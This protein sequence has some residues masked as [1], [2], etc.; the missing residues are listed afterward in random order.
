MVV[1]VPTVLGAGVGTAATRAIGDDE[2]LA[3]A[4]RSGPGLGTRR[5]I[6]SVTTDELTVALTFDDGP[7][8]DITPHVL[9]VLDRYD[10]RASFMLV[11]ARVAASPDLVRRAVAAGHDI[12]N[13]TWS[14]PSLATLDRAGVEAE[15]GRTADVLASVVPDAPVRWFRPPRG[16]LTGAAAHAASSLGY[17]TVLWSCTRGPANV[18]EPAG[19]AGYLDD[20]L[21]PGTIAC[22]HDG[23]GSAGFDGGPMAHQL[24]VKRQVEV[25]ALPLLVERALDRGV[26]FVTITDLVA[27]GDP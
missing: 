5:M 21:E 12:G 18:D 13:H 16:I 26:R 17:D 2:G 9:G 10:V 22:L 11:G 4:A 24:R 25:Q 15:L 7:D 6:W 23:L 1:A 3:T 20:H 27:S 14:H 8:P 19:V